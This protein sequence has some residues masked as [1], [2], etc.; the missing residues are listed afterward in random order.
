MKRLGIYHTYDRQNIVDGYI[1]YMLKELKTCVNYLVV[2][3]NE[4]VIVHGV[5]TLEKY[6]DEIFYRDNI[7]LDAGGFKDVLTKFIGWEKVLSFDELVLVNDSLFGPFCPMKDIF[8][9]MNK[10][11]VDFWGLSGHSEYKKQG[12]DSFPRH[13]QSFFL[14]VRSSML[15]SNHF[16]NYWEN[17]PYYATYNQVV[18]EYEMQFTRHF[19]IL[20][21]T[22]DVYTDI[23]ANNSL[24]PA[25]N[26]IQYKKIPYELIKKRKFPFLKKQ[27]IADDKLDEQTQQELYQAINYIDKATDYDVNLIWKNIIRTLN[28]ADLQRNFHLQYI[29]STEP[30]YTI[31]NRKIVIIVC[32]SHNKSSE[33]ILEYLENLDFEIKVIADKSELLNDYRGHGYECEI[34]TQEDRIK[35]MEHFYTYDMVCLVNDTDLTSE[36]QPSYIGKSYFYSIWN[37]LINN[38]SHILAIQE[39]FDTTPYL[40]ILTPPQPNFGK[41]LGSLGRGWDGKYQEIYGIVKEKKINC[42]IS[43]D[44]PPFS[45]MENLWIRGKLLKSL[46]DWKSEELQYLPYA[47]SYIAQD[48]GY[49]SGIVESLEYAG[50]NEVNMHY[51]LEQIVDLVRENYGEFEDIVE[52]KKKIFQ[53]SLNEFCRKY[54]RIL[55][56]GT[57]ILA[58]K[59]KPML[60]KPEAYVVSDGHMK[61]PELDGIPV[62]YLSEV[63]N[64]DDCGMILCL[65]KKNQVQAIEQLKKYGIYNYLCI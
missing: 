53:T 7:G 5:K 42:Q 35:Y 12:I 62:K 57:G 24:N 2:V 6:A 58:R 59:Y 52:L 63:E 46:K 29:I 51:Y 39:L 45:K 49:Y 27:Q 14:V 50:M 18:R 4:M 22:Y 26:Y 1:G 60:P 56:Y 13:I 36:V 21:Y 48:L 9:E 37:N 61:L 43:E 31:Y 40:G 65:N 55:I 25:N 8:A 15:H 64:I 32:I 11:T 30:K 10:K 28:I 38:N 16:K 47:W 3:C 54:S 41:F 34:I 33:Y 19:S 23:D 17:M 44:K 20:G